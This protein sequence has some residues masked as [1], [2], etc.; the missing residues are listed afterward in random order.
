EQD[1]AFWRSK[2][3][4]LGI[5]DKSTNSAFKDAP[6]SVKVKNYPKHNRLLGLLSKD[7]YQSD[8]KLSYMPKLNRMIKNNP[9]LLPYIKPHE[10]LGKEEILQREALFNE[11]AKIIWNPNRLLE[12]SHFESTEETLA[13]CEDIFGETEVQLELNNST[14]SKVNL[15][16]LKG[17]EM[18]MEVDNA[19][20]E[21]IYYGHSNGIILKTIQKCPLIKDV[22]K[23]FIE[24]PGLAGVGDAYNE[25]IADSNTTIENGSFC[26]TAARLAHTY[27]FARKKPCRTPLRNIHLHLLHRSI[28]HILRFPQKALAQNLRQVH[29]N[30]VRHSTRLVHLS[31][32]RK[33]T[34]LSNIP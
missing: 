22:D 30:I 16:N 33:V 17:K 10:K 1:F 27:L 13:F 12:S 6:Y 4:A 9:Q 28:R 34:L 24:L 31:L 15:K 3:G 14:D 8:G 32:L 20:F 7:S 11:L 21:F 2:I 26:F 5:L 25:I 29:L 18:F 19:R 23:L